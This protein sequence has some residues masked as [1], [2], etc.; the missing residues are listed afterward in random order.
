MNTPDLDTTDPKMY[1]W[2]WRWHGYAG[3]F[4]VP[5]I[6]W[7][8]LTGLPYVWENGL[9]NLW[10]PEYRALTPQAALHRSRPL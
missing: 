3:L 10:H 7:M 6:F 1:H 5:F 9:E 2:M 4:I 8:S